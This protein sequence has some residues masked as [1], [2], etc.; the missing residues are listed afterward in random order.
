MG[1]KKSH[2]SG[3]FSPSAIDDANEID[4]MT[5]G[6]LPLLIPGLKIGGDMKVRGSISPAGTFNKASQKVSPEFGALGASEEFESPKLHSTP[7]R[8]KEALSRKISGHKR[9]HYSLPR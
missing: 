2:S 7:A 1:H 5:A 3:A 8:R 6:L 4:A 9:N